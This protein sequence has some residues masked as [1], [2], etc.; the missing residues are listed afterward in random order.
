MLPP[1][2]APEH[3]TLASLSTLSRSCSGSDSCARSYICT[4]KIV[5]G[6]PVMTSILQPM[7]GA[8]SSSSSASTPD[9]D[10]SD[11]YPEIEASAYG[12][13]AKSGRLICMVAPNGNRSHNNSSRYPTIRRSEAF[14]AR[15]TS[16]GLVRNLNP[17]FNIVRVQ[18]IMETIQRMTPHGSPLLSSLS[19]GP[20]WQTLSSQR[21]RP[22]LGVIE[23]T[24]ATSLKIGDA[25]G[26]EHHPHNGGL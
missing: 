10:S 16:Y 25:S 23:M 19:K 9:Q 2:P 17:D 8:S 20:R 3:P 15:T 11:D 5:W 24:S 14:D 26:S 22:T 13:P 21:S 12:E 6:I 18:A 4:A 1:G 7:A